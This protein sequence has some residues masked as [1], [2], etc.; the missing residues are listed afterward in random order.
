MKRNSIPMKAMPKQFLILLVFI[1][2]GSLYSCEDFFN[3]EQD[4]II[5]ENDFLIDWHEY[6]AA[7]LG[8]YF[9]QQRLMDQIIVLGELRGDLLEITPNADKDLMDVYNFEIAPDNKYASPNGFYELIAA[10]NNLGRKLEYK[11]PEV[12]DKTKGTTDYDRLYGEILCMRAW[13][14]YNAVKIYGKIPYIWPSLTSATEI[15]SYLETSQTYNDVDDII[16]GSDGYHNDTILGETITLERIYLDL[17]MVIDTFTTQLPKKIKGIGVIHNLINKDLTWNVTIWNVDAYNCL[18]GDMHLHNSDLTAAQ[19]FFNPILY[20]YDSEASNIKHGLDNKF[21][22]GNWSN[23]LTEIDP[24]EHIF[25]LQFDKAYQQQHDLQK[26]FSVLEPNQY[27]LKPTKI[28]ID[29]W[30]TIWKG[31][32]ISKDLTNPA[33]TYMIESGIPG[34]FYRGYGHSYAYMKNGSPMRS[35]EVMLMLYYK[36][37]GNYRD[38]E[39]LMSGV[40]TV[41]YKYTYNKDRFDQDANIMIYRA[42]GIHLFVAE[43]FAYWYYDKN[44]NGVYNT[45]LNKGITILNNGAYR[46]PPDGNQLGVRGRVG[47]GRGEDAIYVENQIYKHD[48]YTNEVIGYLDYTNNLAAKQKYL[49]DQIIT[50][51]ARELAYEGNR[52]YDLM[53]V[54]KRR[55][56]NSYLADK[57]AAKF[58]GAKAEQIHAHL[59]VEDNWY[60]PLE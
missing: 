2:A 47:F 45:N 41:V 37:I 49:E 40:D 46:D 58:S 32:N 20:N 57:V 1:M 42:A 29:N 19:D 60:L 27:M 8:L 4:L 54:A 30:E 23:I 59:M 5:K 50:E 21:S 25:S 26:L 33:N 18:M 22:N 44:N 7:E 34:D 48:P 28:A 10:C 16:Y 12:L 17:D 53:R 55:G 9:L 36:S 39:N 24:D 38:V 3:P 13:A 6:R 52:F 14:Y 31:M 11:H 35:N 51:R 15:S 43:I 56:D